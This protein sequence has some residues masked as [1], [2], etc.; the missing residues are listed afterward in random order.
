MVKDYQEEFVG[1]C[2]LFFNPHFINKYRRN[3]KFDRELKKCTESLWNSPTTQSATGWTATTQGFY[4]A[5]G[6]QEETWEW[7][8]SPVLVNHF[9]V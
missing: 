7:D 3:N 6:N 2:S 9:Q 5:I 4:L 8:S 1:Y